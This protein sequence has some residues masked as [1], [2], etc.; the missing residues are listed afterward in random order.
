[1]PEVAHAG[2]DHGEVGFVGGADLGLKNFGMRAL[3]C[4]RLEKNFGTWY[5][6]FRPIYGPFEAGLDRFVKLDKPDF[7]GKAAA[8]K[9]KAEGPK[10][11]RVFL[12][13]LVNL[14]GG[15]DSRGRTLTLR[16]KEM[17]IIGVLDDWR[18]APHYFDLS[19][20]AYAEAA[21]VYAP[22]STALALSF[23]T[24][25]NMNCWNDTNDPRSLNAPCAWLQYWVELDSPAAAPAFRDYLL[26]YGV[27]VGN[28]V[29]IATA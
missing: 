15:A 24:W 6:E 11:T 17:R 29:V 19:L 9:E 7:I 23:G 20:G 1:M 27:K 4:L 21:E 14:F 28:H 22:F 5:R 12:D 10:R 16:D 25:G 3:L 18:P 2:E 13:F 8:V 26:R